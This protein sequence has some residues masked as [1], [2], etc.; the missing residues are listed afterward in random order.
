MKK[1]LNIAISDM[2]KVDE[3]VLFR[4]MAN[5]FNNNVIAKCTYVKEVHKMMVEF[6]SNFKRGMQPKE[7]GDLLL[8]TFDKSTKKL[9]L[10][11]L[12]TK[13]RRGSYRKFLN[14]K[15][16]IYQWEL[17][18]YKPDVYNKSRINI[19]KHILNFR[20]D[21]KSITAYG[22]FYY[23][24]NLKMIDFLYA[25]P[26]LFA[27]KILVPSPSSTFVFNCPNLSICKSSCC[28]CSTAICPTKQACK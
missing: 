27:P 26:E 21:Y 8:L 6:Y 16:D 7:I 9:R 17:L 24:K 20:H 18:Y 5:Q 3:I 11:V 22:V 12:Q 23:D 2:P 14:C 1:E 13:Y 28:G 25:L 19:P 15:A 10:C 4:E